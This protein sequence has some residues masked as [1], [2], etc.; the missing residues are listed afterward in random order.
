[1]K[2]ILTLLTAVVLTFAMVGCNNDTP[3][4]VPESDLPDPTP[5]TIEGT[6]TYADSEII[7]IDTDTSH[8]TFMLDSETDLSKAADLAEGDKV[9]I[10]YL[11]AFALDSDEQEVKVVSVERT[12]EPNSDSS[13]S[14]N[15]ENPDSSEGEGAES[16]P[17]DEDPENLPNEGEGESSEDSGSSAA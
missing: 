6:V 8:H 1:M 13:E 12:S 4:S 9:I 10:T 3:S 5:V 11:G 17:D 14:E 2:K 15:P 7:S 16:T